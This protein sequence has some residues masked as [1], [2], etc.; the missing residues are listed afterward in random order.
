MKKSIGFFFFFF[1]LASILCGCVAGI[2]V[3]ARTLMA[4]PLPTSTPLVIST[5]LPAPEFTLLA[6]GDIMLGRRIYKNIQKRGSEEYPFGKVKEVLS[7]GDLLFGNLEA[8]F[9]KK[10]TK[11]IS[12]TKEVLLRAPV[13]AAPILGRAGFNMVSLA[14]NHSLDYGQVGLETTLKVLDQQQITAIGVYK[15][16]EKKQTP[17]YL[18][19]KGI[20]FVF[21]AYSS[22]SPA[23]FDDHQ[24]DLVVAPSYLPEVKRSIQEASTKSDFVIVSFHWG[25]EDQNNPTEAQI[26]MAHAAVDAGAAL[27]IGHHPHVL[28][29]VEIYKQGIIFYSL[30]NFVF[31]IQREATWQSVILK[32][33]FQKNG[34]E[35]YKLIPVVLEEGQPQL[36]EGDRKAAILKKI[37][38]YSLPLNSISE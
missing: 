1:L 13:E 32:V 38:E 9:C 25:I 3:P 12:L 16:K 14:N 11:P 2:L 37:Y 28:Q 10:G 17:F 30:G 5:A 6:V 24:I 18:E 36:A 23:L 7:T 35:N 20:R 8:P 29:G 19:Q 33:V 21:L 31:D 26:K 34:I 27:V 4:Q 22:V 15:R